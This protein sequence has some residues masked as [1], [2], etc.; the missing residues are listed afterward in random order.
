MI[1]SDGTTSITISTADG[2][3]DFSQIKSRKVTAGGELRIRTTGDRY[4]VSETFEASGSE[5]SDI[6][7]LLN[8]NSSEY[9][10]TPTTVPPEFSSSYFPMSVDIT[11]AG[12]IERIYSGEIK[13]F[14]SLEIESNELFNS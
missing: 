12:K 4:S 9:F 10:Y 11:Y 7:E 1:I 3:G 2:N 8:N 5:L 6:L 14:I 13:Y